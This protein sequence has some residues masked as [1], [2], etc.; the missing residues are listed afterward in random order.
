[1]ND[2]TKTFENTFAVL[3]VISFLI[4]TALDNALV[5]AAGS[6]ILLVVGLILFRNRFSKG[7]ILSAIVAGVIA[8]GVAY[9][10]VRALSAL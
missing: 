9:F 7:A 10:L 6:I 8:F 5:M 3:A 4:L 2:K 1:M